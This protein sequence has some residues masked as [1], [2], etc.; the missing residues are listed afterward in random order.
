[1]VWLGQEWLGLAWELM[2]NSR[3]SNTPWGP[4]GGLTNWHKH[5]FR[6]GDQPRSQSSCN[7]AWTK[8]C[9]KRNDWLFPDWW[10]EVLLKRVLCITMASHSSNTHST[11]TGIRFPDEVFLSASQ[12][13]GEGEA[14]PSDAA[15]TTTL[16]GQANKNEY[17][18]QEISMGTYGG[19]L[20]HLQ[21]Q[22]YTTDTGCQNPSPPNHRCHNYHISITVQMLPTVMLI[23]LLYKVYNSSMIRNNTT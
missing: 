2:K 13:R 12:I 3:A 9:E 21:A 20:A 23:D 14:E 10:Q 15:I 16:S 6:P 17:F 11:Y 7:D 1:M 8:V 18:S 19:G 4:T 5:A 22:T